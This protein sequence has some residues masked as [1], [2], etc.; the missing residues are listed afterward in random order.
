MVGEDGIVDVKM[1]AEDVCVAC[2]L[3]GTDGL[4]ENGE[5]AGWLPS[6]G[7]TA[8]LLVPKREVDAAGLSP[9]SG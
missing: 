1:E 8:G 4:K 3:A 5:A 2:P 7:L 6:V 9:D